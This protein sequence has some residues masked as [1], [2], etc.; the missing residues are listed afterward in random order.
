MRRSIL[1][2]AEAFG[3]TAIVLIDIWFLHSR[4]AWGDLLPTVFA[5][6]SFIAHRETL[7][8][9]GFTTRGLAGMLSG[10]AV[11]LLTA[12]F[13]ADDP[14]HLLLRGCIYFAWCVLQ[15]LLFQNLVY[16]RIRESLG[17]GW[18]TALLAGIL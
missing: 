4:S 16:R 1:P 5:I 6:V 17:P 9:L 13:F 2:L 14:L 18:S 8:S 10:Y 7:Q 3:F 15:Q 11:L 12:C